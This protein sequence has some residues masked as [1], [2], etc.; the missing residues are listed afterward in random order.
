MPEGTLVIIGGHED[1]KG[2]KTILHEVA[3]RCKGKLV[4][5][6]VASREP[7]GTYE[8]YRHIFRD[9]GVE[10]ANLEIRA[11]GEALDPANFEIMDDAAGIFFTGGDQLKITSQL[12]DTP[13]FQR[14]RELYANGGVVA[15]TS[16]GASVMCETMLIGGPGE[17]S[18]RSD[19]NLRMGPGLGFL[20]DAVVDQH[21]AERGRFGR[22]L[23]AIAR[24]PR[25]L[26]LGLD[27]D[28]AI[29]VEGNKA[30]YVLGA[31]AVYVLDG[32]NVSYSNIGEE[33]EYDTLSVFRL[34][35]HVLS[36]GDRFDLESREPEAS[37][38]DVKPEALETTA[39][40]GRRQRSHKNES[41]DKNGDERG[42]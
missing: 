12:G 6:T 36:E 39:A 22:L 16:A 13:I 30:F 23:G 25:N 3:R 27:E 9:F 32:R 29:V 21:F 34:T 35:L 8:E 17:E 4:V 40:H 24:N 19:D 33:E 26:G 18:H 38:G 28:T 11:R 41:H 20:R 2:E 15:G 5:T 37:R 31:G 10:T 7:E 14:T 42:D 1:R